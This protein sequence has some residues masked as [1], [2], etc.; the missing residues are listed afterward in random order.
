[1]D[2]LGDTKVFVISKKNATL[3]G[4]QKWNGTM[5]EFVENTIPY[6]EQYH[7]RSNSETGFATDKK[8]LG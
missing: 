6:P 8:M 7:Q 1:M 4:S 3:N 5:K 2:K